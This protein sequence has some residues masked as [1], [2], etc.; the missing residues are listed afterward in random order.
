MR[1]GGGEERLHDL[2]DADLAHLLLPLQVAVVLAVD[3]VLH[4]EHRRRL[5][6][7]VVVVHVVSD[8][9]QHV[10]VGHDEVLRRVAVRDV[11]ED[12]ERLRDTIQDM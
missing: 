12:A 10:L 2:V 7:R 1:V 11:A 3:E 6:L 9:A 4:A 8:L 5:Q